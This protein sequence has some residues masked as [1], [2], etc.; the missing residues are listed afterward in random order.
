MKHA[1]S[2]FAT[3]GAL[4]FG[5]LST[6][7]DPLRIEWTEI[8]QTPVPF[9]YAE[10]VFLSADSISG[11]SPNLGAVVQMS[12]EEGLTERSVLISANSG[13]TWA[14]FLLPSGQ[15][16]QGIPRMT[17]G[18]GRFVFV[19]QESFESAMI[20]NVLTSEG[21]QTSEDTFGLNAFDPTVGYSRKLTGLEFLNGQFLALISG[22]EAFLS[23]DGLAWTRHDLPFTPQTNSP[24]FAFT[25][26]AAEWIGL[27]ASSPGASTTYTLVKSVNGLNWN[28]T[29]VAIPGR[30]GGLDPAGSGFSL[31]RTIEVSANGQTIILNGL[32]TNGEVEPPVQEWRFAISND[33]GA[34]WNFPLQ[35]SIFEPL[36]TLA[37]PSEV[38]PS[39]IGKSNNFFYYNVS[40]EG[41]T[42]DDWDTFLA[43]TSDGVS[44]ERVDEN[45]DSLEQRGDAP[46]GAVSYIGLPRAL[47]DGIYNAVGL[48]S[49]TRTELSF[50]RGEVTATPTPVPTP[51]PTPEPAPVP[52][53]P[54]LNPQPAPP[55]VVI[56]PVEEQIV[57]LEQRIVDVRQ[58]VRNP[59]ARAN[60][61]R[62]LNATIQRLRQQT[63]MANLSPREREIAQL[64]SQ[65]ADVRRRVQNP[66]ARAAQIRR[67][68]ATLNELRA[69][70]E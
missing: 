44:W 12:L 50:F 32:W 3:A 60:Q 59:V 67:L 29:G 28:S 22:R 8:T 11:V 55:V 48:V 5:A 33:G 40:A 24:I 7:A 39:P 58:R 1:L 66:T 70:P 30:L 43:R 19:N 42:P 10:D 56:S 37:N 17:F 20:P 65:I 35:S 53:P 25:A 31:F 36:T 23:S 6:Y 13:A 57:S 62:N 54:A 69:Q 38:S 49:E 47:A 45:I 2:T 63:A 41:A 52:A 26:S 16:A 34:S 9:S 64:Q 15:F 21:V 14:K 61:L 4:F 18:N 27:V 51:V 68:T 46:E